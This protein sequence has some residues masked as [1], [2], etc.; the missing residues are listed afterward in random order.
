MHVFIVQLYLMGRWLSTWL[1]QIRILNGLAM[2]I[3]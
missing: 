2:D 1:G 3:E